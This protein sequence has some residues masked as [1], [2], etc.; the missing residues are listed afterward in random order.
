[1]TAWTFGDQGGTQVLSLQIGLI[2]HG[3]GARAE[4]GHPRRFSHSPGDER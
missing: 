3:Q 1:M 4:T 2:R